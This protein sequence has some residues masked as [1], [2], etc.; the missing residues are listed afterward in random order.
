M[1][2][3][4]R[5]RKSGGSVYQRSNLN[6]WWIR[7]R[8]G[9]GELIK[10]S[11]GVKDKEEAERFLRDRLNDRDD[12]RLPAILAGKTQTFNEWADWF[13][14]KRS[15]PRYRSEKTHRDKMEVLKNLRPVFGTRVLSEITP[16]LIED[17]VERR[18]G[19]ERRVR[20]KIG[21][22]Y[23]GLLKPASVHKEFRVLRRILSVAVKKKQIGVN[24]CS[25]VQFPVKIGATTRKPH[26]MAASEQE[27]IEFFAPDYLRDAIVILV[28]MGLR[29]YKELTPMK[30][31]QM[32]LDNEIVHIPDSKT[33]NGIAD[34]PMTKLAR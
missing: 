21:I 19:S 2:K 24:P 11:S 16:E 5:P 13:L 23:S 26:Y 7:Y 9:K 33:K 17:Y 20:T 6:F 32:D 18:L 3:H 34:M 28:E 22:E 4:G 29:P 12:G 1:S 8:D 30:K 15:K 25:A 31:G 14:E 10:E 27:R